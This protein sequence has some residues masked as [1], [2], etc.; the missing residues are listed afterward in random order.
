MKKFQNSVKMFME[1]AKQPVLDKPEVPAEETRLLGMRLV[2]E[3]A[4]FEL[5]ESLGIE[6]WHDCGSML[7]GLKR[8]E[9]A[10][11]GEPN[12]VEI[13]DAIADGIYV[14]L[15]VANAHGID[16]EPILDEVCKNNLA[17]FGPGHSFGPDG[18]LVKP[19]GFKGPDIAA[20][21][22]FQKDPCKIVHDLDWKAERFHRFAYATQPL[23]TLWANISPGDNIDELKYI[24][25]DWFTESHRTAL[26]DWAIANPEVFAA[27]YERWFGRKP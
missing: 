26:I 13:A 21:L 27:E 25:G 1:L 2:A 18:K 19:P 17:K 9:L 11:D 16:V 24:F 20:L 22:E 5:A 15:W 23:V 3:E 14:L 6:L 8:M 12:L 7:G 10:T 4:F